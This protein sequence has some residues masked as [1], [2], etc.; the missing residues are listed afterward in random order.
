MRFLA[1]LVAACPAT[2]ERFRAGLDRSVGDD[3]I[4]DLLALLIAWVAVGN[5]L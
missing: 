4:H 5:D 2:V 1:T 3:H